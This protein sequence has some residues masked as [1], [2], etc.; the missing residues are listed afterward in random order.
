MNSADPLET[1]QQWLERWAPIEPDPDDGPDAEPFGL[2]PLI[3]DVL[4]NVLTYMGDD[5][6]DE[7]GGE[8]TGSCLPTSLA[9]WLLDDDFTTTMAASCHQLADRLDKGPGE[10]F[11]RCTA[12]EV[13]LAI[14]HHL[15]TGMHDD[16]LADDPVLDALHDAL[17]LLDF[18]FEL[19][20]ARELLAD[21]T[22]VDFLSDP[23]H[24]GIEDDTE[25][26]HYFR[27][28]NLHPKDWFKPF[29]DEQAA[30]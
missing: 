30:D 29:D 24:D 14:A 3:A 1:A 15:A 18:R 6:P 5:W 19:D 27:I 21:D 8:L 4:Y 17:G 2:N 26:Q 10:R 13:N 25:L 20:F 7:L 22:D 9:I 11:T 12:D 28:I 23:A 16:V